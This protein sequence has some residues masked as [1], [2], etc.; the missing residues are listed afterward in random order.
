MSSSL[1]P[2]KRKRCGVVSQH[3]DRRPRQKTLEMLKAETN[4]P[5]L[6]KVDGHFDLFLRPPAGNELIIDMGAPTLVRCVGPKVMVHM[7]G[8]ERDPD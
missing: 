5:Q 2:Y 8:S 7:M 6:P 1:F 3:P 4:S